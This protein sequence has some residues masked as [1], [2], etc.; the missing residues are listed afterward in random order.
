[1]KERSWFGLH[2]SIWKIA[3]THIVVDAYTN[4]YAPLL[5]LLIPHLNLS[6]KAAGTLAMCFQMANSVSQLGFG[7]LADRWRPRALVIAGPLLTVIALSFVGWAGSPLMLGL[8]LVL[9]G[10]GGAAFHPPAAALVYKLADHRKGLAM[11]A[12]LSGGSL[13]FAAAPVLFAPF[14]AY[15]GLGWSPLIMIPGL[16]ALSWTLRQVPP[17]QRPE[18]H[19]RSTWA[20]LAPAAVPLTLLY[21]TIVLRT[22]TTYGFMTFAPTLL[23]RQGL[24]I[25]EASSAVSLYLFASGIG[26]LIGGPLSDRV[27]PRRIIVWSLVAAVPFMAMAPR[28]P[29]AGFTAMLAIG[30]LLLQS[31]LPISVTFAQTFTTG[32]AATVSSLMMGFAWGMG[33]LAVPLIGAGADRFGIERTLTAL[34]F[35]PLLAAALAWGLPRGTGQGALPIDDRPI[36]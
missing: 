16:L 14:I 18:A 2:P 6:L 26:G 36:L 33:S 19:E 35:V 34:A 5:P 15:M 13:G 24:T 17:M 12:H 20:T 27:G 22:A 1:M 3:S 7:T 4:I 23:T 25:G 32:G 28:L 29:P 9:G 30:G 8:V 10:L 21:F 31:T 11:S